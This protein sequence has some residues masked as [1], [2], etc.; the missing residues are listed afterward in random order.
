MSVA[1]FFVLFIG[2]TI[3]VK[4]FGKRRSFRDILPVIPFLLYRMSRREIGETVH[5]TFQMISGAAITLQFETAAVLGLPTAVI[6]ALQGAGA[7]FGDMICINYIASVC[8][9]SGG[10]FIPSNPLQ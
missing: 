9:T 4:V 5:R 7:A 2:I 3:L 1:A 10:I 6:V 8:A